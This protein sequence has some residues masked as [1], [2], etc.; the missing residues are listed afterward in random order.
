M[1]APAAP[2]DS[3][4]SSTTPRLRFV[5]RAGGDG[6]TYDVRL[7]L[8]NAGLLATLRHRTWGTIRFASDPVE[9]F[10]WHF[11]SL[12]SAPDDSQDHARLEAMAAL[13]SRQIVPPGV[14]KC[15]AALRERVAGLHVVA[16][17]PWIPWEFLRIESHPDS[18]RI[19][20]SH[21]GETFALT[22]GLPGVDLAPGL[23][24]SRIG[25]VIPDRPGLAAVE[26][27]A[28]DLEQLACQ[29]IRTVV[30]IPARLEAV[31]AALRGGECDVWH[32]ASHGDFQSKAPDLSRIVLEN[33]EELTPAHLDGLGAG[34]GARRPMVFL[35]LCSAAQLG[36][37][38]ASIGGWAAQFLAAGAA[39]FVGPTLR[40]D[41]RRARTF[42]RELYRELLRGT[43]LGE[44]ARLA[45]RAIAASADP[46]WL[47]YAVFAHPM[48]AFSAP[49]ASPPTLA[50]SEPTEE[51]EPLQADLPRWE[52]SRPPGALLRAEYGIVR[53]HGRDRELAELVQWCRNE[54]RVAVRL[55]TGKGGMGKTRLALEIARHLKAEGW[56]AG[57]LTPA[58]VAAPLAAWSLLRRRGGRML[59]IVDYA[60]TRRAVLVP[61]LREIVRAEDGPIRVVLLARAALDWWDQLRAEGEGVGE[62]L[63]GSATSKQ[64]LGALAFTERQRVQS[65]G[66]AL[67]DFAEKLGRAEPAATLEQPAADYFERVL[68]LHMSALAAIEGVAV[69]GELGILDFVL[70]RERRH[71]Q[72]LAHA[73]GIKKT[74][75]RGIGR[76]MAAITL[77]GGVQSLS[78]AVAVVEALRFFAGQTRDVLEAVGRLLR[79]TYPD[80]KRGIEP[81]LPDLLGEHLVQRELEDG[82]DE[83][84]D[85]V[86]GPR[87]SSG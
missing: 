20:G 35:N 56:Q 9:F 67:A 31:L 7:E 19:D 51:E 84:L 27:E 32:F 81:I 39:A 45:R 59:L 82:A 53:F 86:L 57:F 73:A 29:G 69:K 13:F 41:D 38:L 26:G 33:D 83:L 5:R 72:G 17:A 71:W 52:P 16:D 61:L 2:D 24:L 21:L 75:V 66:Y 64:P 50:T 85:L 10:S 80:G 22:R 74:L 34:F 70:D 54:P 77:A 55:Y 36:L 78:H 60:E 28:T 12:R 44:A 6:L 46:S 65:Y 23:S 43:P 40:V 4:G 87:T 14:R 30:R 79:E 1:A 42:S 76:A 25:F 47:A 49:A 68:L 58:A 48:A 18:R 15:L 8:E 37:S 62:L 11:R 3:T 63:Q